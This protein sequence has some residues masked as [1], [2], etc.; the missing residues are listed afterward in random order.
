MTN[1]LQ[2]RTLLS[3]VTSGIAVSLAG[4]AD[5]T[6]EAAETN[7][8]PAETPT[9]STGTTGSERVLESGMNIFF[10]LAPDRIAAVDPD[11]GEVRAE[12]TDGIDDV[13]WGDAI[14]LV[15]GDVY[16]CDGSRAQIVVIDPESMSLRDRIDLGPGPTHAF[17][18]RPGEFDRC[19]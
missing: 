2:R 1:R 12:I 11:S 8:T 10:A 19:R 17:Q 9:E 13:S 3:G 15:N 5:E 4:C 14:Q 18:P 16:A 6:D 7:E